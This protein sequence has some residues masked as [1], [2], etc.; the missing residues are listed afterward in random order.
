M[1][2]PLRSHFTPGRGLWVAW[3]M[4]TGAA[5]GSPSALGASHHRQYACRWWLVVVDRHRGLPLAAGDP[6]SPLVTFRHRWGLVIAVSGSQVV[7]G[8]ASP[9]VVTLHC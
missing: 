1:K 7:E 8:S 6:F 2:C 5:D 9:V 3:R 4:G